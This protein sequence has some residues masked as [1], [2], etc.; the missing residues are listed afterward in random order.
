MSERGRM[1]HLLY[2]H[3]TKLIASFHLLYLYFLHP[4]RSFHFTHTALYN[5]WLRVKGDVFILLSR[6]PSTLQSFLD[7]D[8]T[9]E[10]GLIFISNLS[11][12]QLSISQPFNCAK[13]IQPINPR[14][15]LG[16]IFQERLFKAF[17]S[18][19]ITFPITLDTY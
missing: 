12:P 13:R 9:D 4:F 14:T 6:L 7:T 19:H 17:F 18:L 10:R 11:T 16:E 15:I 5:N 1:R 8:D 2:P 3:A